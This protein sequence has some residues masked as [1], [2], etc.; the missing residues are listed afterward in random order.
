MLTAPLHLLRSRQP[1]TAWH[2]F[3]IGQRGLSRIEFRPWKVANE[4]SPMSPQRLTAPHS[5]PFTYIRMNEQNFSK[6]NESMLRRAHAKAPSF[7][8][9]LETYA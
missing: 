6:E 3:A 2:F 4:H 7:I 8:E 1:S 5:M 9:A